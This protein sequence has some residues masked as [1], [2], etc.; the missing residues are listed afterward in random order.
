MR[1]LLS[2]ILTLGML[3][4][5]VTACAART[6]PSEGAPPPPTYPGVTDD[7][8]RGE[9]ANYPF[10]QVVPLPVEQPRLKRIMAE[11][12]AT[13]FGGNISG[14]RIAALRA[15]YAEAVAQGSG[16]EIGRMS[17]I[18]NVKYVTNV[19]TSR[20]R[21]FIREYRIIN[22]G[23][24][25]QN[26][27]V[28]KVLIEADVVEDGKVLGDD[29]Y[30]ALKTY[31]ELLGNPKLLIILPEKR[32]Y[33]AGSAASSAAAR[34]R[35]DVQV[36]AGDTNVKITREATRNPQQGGVPGQ[37]ARAEDPGDQMRSTEAALAQ[38]FTHYGYQVVTSDDLLAEGLCSEDTLSQARAG[39]TARAV[40]VARAA[41]ADLALLGVLRLSEEQVTAAGVD[42]VAVT[43]EVS[44]KAL[45]VSSGKLVDAFHR[46]ERASSQRML[47]AY[48]DC[49][50]KV[51]DTLASALAW[52]IPEILSEEFRETRLEVAG[53]TLLQSMDLQQALGFIEGVESVRP[54]QVPSETSPVASFAMLS[55]YV[56]VEPGEVIERCRK[57]LGEPVRLITAS[58]YE[59]R[60]ATGS[61]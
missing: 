2:V 53:I 59:I 22:E 16:I 7:P 48:S 35:T 21:G 6:L 42:L 26:P 14:A 58:K 1:T 37:P 57:A 54:Q 3:V 24:S 43:A 51:A 39:I 25:P 13:V 40:E 32:V 8:A 23:L 41:N 19:M 30:A 27:T 18:K 61:R 49:L 11:G 9:Y 5:S 17:L 12:V 46:T 34:D 10:G 15:A 33:P 47:K 36:A 60:A 38:A 56:F 20:S 52:K 31:L 44:A 45:V 29:Q 4:G 28:Y 50:D 55:G